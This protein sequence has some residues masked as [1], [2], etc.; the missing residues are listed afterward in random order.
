VASLGNDTCVLAGT[1]MP[2]S[3]ALYFQGTD[4]LNNGAGVVFGDGLRCVGG[5]IVRLATKQNG[6][7][8][9]QYPSAGDPPISVRGG[10]V[11]PGMRR[12]QV[13]YRNANP[14][15]CTAATYNLT[16]AVEVTWVQ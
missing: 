10:I 1:G 14:A 15:F 9:S 3:A 5:T 6:A 8:F 7:G 12:Y 13:W 16:N 2:N 11:T 4:R